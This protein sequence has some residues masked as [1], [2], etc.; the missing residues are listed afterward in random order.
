MIDL[1]VDPT[2]TGLKILPMITPNIS[3]VLSD[4]NLL[5]WDTVIGWI[6]IQ[7]HTDLKKTLLFN[8]NSV[9][10]FKEEREGGCPEILN[11]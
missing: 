2:P 10:S 1:T 9:I 8:A 5:R 3:T 11:G 6:G 4:F 7:K